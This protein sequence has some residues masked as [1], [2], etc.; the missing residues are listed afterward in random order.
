MNPSGLI[1]FVRTTVEDPLHI[2]GPRLRHILTDEKVP[3]NKLCPCVVKVNNVALNGMDPNK[4]FIGN[5]KLCHF[6]GDKYTVDT[7][8]EDFQSILDIAVEYI[9]DSSGK[10]IQEKISI[11]YKVDWIKDL[12]LAGRVG[13]Y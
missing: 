10:L 7:T 2:V 5:A 4:L 11:S 8:K 6:F 12:S 1:S 3:S 9:K 13:Y